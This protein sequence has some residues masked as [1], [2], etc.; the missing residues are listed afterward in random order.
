MLPSC[1]CGAHAAAF[2]PASH[3]CPACK[4][5]GAAGCLAQGGPCAVC[6]GTEAPSEQRLLR[7][8][9]TSEDN[10][11]HADLTLFGSDAAVCGTVASLVA[12]LAGSRPA[13]DDS[14]AAAQFYCRARPATLHVADLGSGTGS[15]AR[16]VLQR[17]GGPDVCVVYAVEVIPGRIAAG[18]AGPDVVAVEGSY[19]CDGFGAWAQQRFDFITSNP[20]FAEAA[21]AGAVAAASLG[22]RASGAAVFVMPVRTRQSQHFRRSLHQAGLHEVGFVG[23]GAHTFTPPYTGGTGEAMDAV[24]LKKKGP[25][26]DNG[27]GAP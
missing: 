12:A 21:L 18:S 14:A 6:L 9:R 10:L 16:A 17:L 24:V 13:A 23:L 2:F 11:T 20:P 4:L 19:T 3:T 25:R 22:L 1:C 7:L 8:M 26:D 15:I 27:S 5:P